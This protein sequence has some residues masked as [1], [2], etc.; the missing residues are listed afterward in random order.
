MASKHVESS[1]SI[2]Q[3]F[4]SLLESLVRVQDMILIGPKVV[5]LFH[6]TSELSFK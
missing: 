1:M 3:F 6:K 2:L 4:L 5:S